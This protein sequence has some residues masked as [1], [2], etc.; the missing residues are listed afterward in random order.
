MA[1]VMPDNLQRV[2]RYKDDGRV[3]TLSDRKPDRNRVLAAG[4]VPSGGS[5][6]VDSHGSVGLGRRELGALYQGL[7]HRE[8]RCA[9]TWKRPTR[10]RAN[11]VARPRGLIVIDFIDMEDL[12]N[13]RQVETRLKDCTAL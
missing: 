4:A 2:K 9:R 5:I 11:F 6:V 3:L 1:H 8:T 12:K 10:S 7:G 13:Q